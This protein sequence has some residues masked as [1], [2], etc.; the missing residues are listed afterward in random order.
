M[1]TIVW[2]EVPVKDL[3]RAMKFYQAVFGFE[4]TEI[5]DEGVRR[6]TTLS[7]SGET[8]NPGFSLNQNADFHP[9]DK[10]PLVYLM[11]D[12]DLPETLAKVEAAGGTIVEGKT[13]M[14]SAGFYAT[15]K[16]T[17]GNLFALY[18]MPDAE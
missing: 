2:I 16:D 7:G 12:G 1:L 11:T 10:G 6:T 14:G 4:A 18:G 17:E 9:G 8:G 3:E 5:S 13:E 15:F